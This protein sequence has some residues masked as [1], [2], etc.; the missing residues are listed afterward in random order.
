M[1][2]A[3]KLFRGKGEGEVILRAID[4]QHGSEQRKGSPLDIEYTSDWLHSVVVRI[5]HFS[6]RHYLNVRGYVTCQH[7]IKVVIVPLDILLK[8][9]LHV[10]LG[11]INEPP[12]PF[13]VQHL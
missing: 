7:I 4:L 8:R 10:V 9:V 12:E 1:K 13:V 3:H 2:Q 5:D 6:C 11:Q